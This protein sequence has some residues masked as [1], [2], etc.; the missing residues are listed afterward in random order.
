M[1]QAAEADLFARVL[2]ALVRAL[3]ELRQDVPEG[4]TNDAMVATVRDCDLP[5]YT[6]THPPH[7]LHPPHMA[8][9]SH[10]ARGTVP[11]LLCN[12]Y[13]ML[14]LLLCRDNQTCPKANARLQA[15]PVFFSAGRRTL[16]EL[17]H[18]SATPTHLLFC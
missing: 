10:H 18:S 11:S 15:T 1:L 17:H 4:G 3:S 9:Q 14:R 7:P 2:R 6:L 13:A 8:A 12:F 5:T 16:S